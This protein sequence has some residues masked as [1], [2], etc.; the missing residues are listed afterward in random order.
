LHPGIRQDMT[1]IV[2]QLAAGP[3]GIP[4]QV[5]AFSNDVRWDVYEGIQGNIFDHMLAIVPEFGLALFQNPTGADIR[6][7]IPPQVAANL[8]ATDCVV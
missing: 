7:A 6:R 2:R 1:L 8:A 5:Y 4:I 3:E